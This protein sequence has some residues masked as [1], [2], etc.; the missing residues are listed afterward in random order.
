MTPPPDPGEEWPHMMKQ[1]RAFL[2]VWAAGLV[3][4]VGCPD[5]VETPDA[6]VHPDAT[7]TVRDAGEDPPDAGETPRDAGEAM[8][9]GQMDASPVDSGA[10]EDAGMAPV[11]LEHVGVCVQ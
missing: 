9:A 3:V 1:M 4:L 10:A 11:G 5:E 7:T 8:D 6:T 2:P